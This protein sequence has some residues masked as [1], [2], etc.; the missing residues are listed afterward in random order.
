MLQSKYSIK[1]HKCR[2]F[3]LNYGIVVK[4][5]HRNTTETSQNTDDTNNENILKFFFDVGAPYPYNVW[6]FVDMNHGLYGLW[7]W[8]SDHEYLSLM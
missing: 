2:N 1:M 8:Q 3:L 5:F 7:V 6:G 4:T